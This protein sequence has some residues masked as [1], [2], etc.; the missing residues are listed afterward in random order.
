MPR[1]IKASEI[2]SYLFCHKAWKYQRENV[3]P[4]NQ[5]ELRA[6]TALHYAHGR[7]VI[8]IGFTRVLAV[9]FLMAAVFAF[10]LF[11]LS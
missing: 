1:T 8:A 6:G 4:D 10:G 9:I 11:Y 5:A 3:K 2:G 7:K